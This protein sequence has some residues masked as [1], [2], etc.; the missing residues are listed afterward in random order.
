M[1]V[2]QAAEG[3]YEAEEDKAPANAVTAKPVY[4]F[5]INLEGVVSHFFLYSINL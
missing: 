3:E 1:V 4:S 5:V 2:V